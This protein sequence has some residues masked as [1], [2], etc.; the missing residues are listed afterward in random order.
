[1]SDFYPTFVTQPNWVWKKK[2]TR[3]ENAKPS[4]VK[5]TVTRLYGPKRETKR[6][7]FSFIHEVHLHHLLFFR[8][9][10]LQTGFRWSRDFAVSQ[11]LQHA[12]NT[13]KTFLFVI[14]SF[15]FSR[16]FSFSSRSAF[17]C[18]RIFIFAIINFLTGC[19]GTGWQRPLNHKRERKRKV[20]TKK[21]ANTP[22]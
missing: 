7:L 9:Q 2:K 15:L 5:N 21:S 13:R 22:W 11:D 16:W 18:L 12:V 20:T 3:S 8:L 19:E 1:M 14:T 4:R 17:W 6:F 10:P